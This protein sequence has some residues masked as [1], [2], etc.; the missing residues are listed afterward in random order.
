M[1]PNAKLVIGCLHRVLRSLTD[2]PLRYEIEEMP[3]GYKVW[4]HV[5]AQCQVMI[6]SHVFMERLYKMKGASIM[7]AKEFMAAWA[8]QRNTWPATDE[9]VLVTRPN[10]Y[11]PRWAKKGGVK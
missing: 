6:L 7:I 3:T 2:R 9:P 10:D 5:G 8:S 4:V 1:N 11:R